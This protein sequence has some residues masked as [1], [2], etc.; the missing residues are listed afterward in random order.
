[1]K[2][3]SKAVYSNMKYF[4]V[5]R[6]VCVCV[7]LSFIF[8][9]P[10]HMIKINTGFSDENPKTIFFLNIS[11]MYTKP[12]IPKTV[13]TNTSLQ[14]THQFTTCTSKFYLP[15][16]FRYGKHVNTV[17]QQLAAAQQHIIQIMI[18]LFSFE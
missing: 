7:R 2:I 14:T 8:C 1:M 10:L 5:D 6:S 3:Q 12:K 17:F 15:L 16:R 4:S 11:N 9:M 18:L 13:S